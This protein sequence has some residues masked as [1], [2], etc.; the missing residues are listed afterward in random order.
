M[1]YVVR[2]IVKNKWS[3]DNLAENYYVVEAQTADGAE[4]KV[5]AIEGG[6]ILAIESHYA[7]HI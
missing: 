7:E 5:K 1:T 2:I 6:R 3:P 4:A